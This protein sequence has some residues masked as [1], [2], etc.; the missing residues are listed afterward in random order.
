MS[1]NDQQLKDAAAFLREAYE[2]SLTHQKPS[3]G[4]PPTFCKRWTDF[5]ADIMFKRW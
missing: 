4:T 5:S 3:P 2:S 1:F